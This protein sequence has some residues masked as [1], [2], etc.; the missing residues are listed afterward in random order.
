MVGAGDTRWPSQATDGARTIV[1]SAH[2]EGCT[3]DILYL[4][5]QSQEPSEMVVVEE[6]LISL[7]ISNI[8]L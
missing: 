1:S 2:R 6:R 5:T 8:S 7:T 4:H 3:E